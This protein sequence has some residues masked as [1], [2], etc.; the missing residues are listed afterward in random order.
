MT[1]TRNPFRD[2]ETL[3][4]KG[5]TTLPIPLLRRKDPNDPFNLSNCVHF[6]NPVMDRESWTTHDVFTISTIHLPLPLFSS[7]VPS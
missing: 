7:L 2:G 5:G 6:V 4:V 1:M 3:G